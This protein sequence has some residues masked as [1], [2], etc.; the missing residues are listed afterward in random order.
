M[1]TTPPD[2]ASPERSF[3]SKEARN[4]LADLQRR[5]YETGLYDGPLP[6]NLQDSPEVQASELRKAEQAALR[7]TEDWAGF[8]GRRMTREDQAFARQAADNFFR[9]KAP[10]LFE[11]PGSFQEL[12]ETIKWVEN[13]ARIVERSIPAITVPV[14]RPLVGSLP[15][16]RV[17]AM[18]IR[19][20]NST[21]HIIVFES[22]L[23]HF[24]WLFCKTIAL[25]MPFKEKRDQIIFS[26]D[27]ASVLRRIKHD[28]TI[29]ERFSEIVE[30]YVVK[31]LPGLAR[32]YPIT[33]PWATQAWLFDQSMQFFII[34]HE[35]SHILH[36]HTGR[37]TAASV[38]GSATAEV[39]EWD[40]QLEVNADTLAVLLLVASP[41]VKTG[42]ILR[43]AGV[44]LFFQAMSIIER[45][46]TLLMTGEER[47]SAFRSGTHPA[48]SIRLKVALRWA[49]VCVPEPEVYQGIVSQSD[50]LQTIIDEL[51]RRVRPRFVS[52]RARG[53]MP[54]GMWRLG[55]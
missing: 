48:N 14:T 39:L 41:D 45:A 12:A 54:H 38:S 2:E 37:G 9:G 30:A 1:N 22:Q 23:F 15:T 35:Y 28:Q 32:Y 26:F 34:A 43:F 24:C 17:N 6:Q 25:A 7:L 8:Q 21:E 40:Q 13:A 19:V 20:P 29:V 27:K 55:T 31:G 49:E 16:G 53:I 47:Q 11:N 44:T 18:A 52:M 46:V 33:Q 50:G 42:P 51:W 3:G 5:I 10:T 4:F 36:G